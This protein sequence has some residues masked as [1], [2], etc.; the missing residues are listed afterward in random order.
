ME[1]FSSN[2]SSLLRTIAD[3][4]GTPSGAYN[5][6]LDGVSVK[7]AETD[8]IKIVSKTDKYIEI[9]CKNGLLRVFEYENLSVVK[10]MV[11]HRFR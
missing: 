3:L 10:L 9:L 6:R 8:N 4:D 5:I 1:L 11:G 2:Q 7:R